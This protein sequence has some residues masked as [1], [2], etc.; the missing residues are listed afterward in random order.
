MDRFSARDSA[1]CK[2][3]RVANVISSLLLEMPTTL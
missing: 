3:G 2:V 1:A